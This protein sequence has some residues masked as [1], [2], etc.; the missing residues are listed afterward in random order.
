MI[1]IL[2]PQKRKVFLVIL[3]LFACII[4]KAQNRVTGLVTGNDNK[5]PIIGASVKIKGSTTGTSTNVNGAFSI[6]AKSTDVLEISSIGYETQSVTVGNQTSL[7]VVLLAGTKALNEVV[8]TGYT[9]QRKKDITGAVAVVDVASLKSVPS[10]T[11]ESLLQGQAS[12]VT[13]INSGVPGGNSNVRVRGITSFGNS[14]PLVI[15]DGTPGSLH[16]LNVNDIESM[17]V[18][19][20][21]GSAAIY[22]V[23]G[24]N[25]VVVVTTKKGKQGKAKINFESYVGTQRPLQGNVFNIANPTETGNAIWQEFKNSGIAITPDTYKNSQYGYGSTPVVPYYITPIAGQQGNPNADPSKYALYSNQ[26]TRANQQGTDWFHEIFKPATMQNY[27]LAASGG[28]DKSNFYFS[29]G[30]LD[31][32]GTMIQTHLKRYTARINTNFNIK[33]HIRVGENAYLFYRQN[34]GLPGT[35]QN[36]GNPISYTYRQSPL[37][38]VFDIVG[39]YAGTNS[40]GLGNPQNPYA[41][42]DRTKNNT[43]NDWQMNGNVFAEA[44]FLKHLTARTSFGG[45]IDNYTYNN[46]GY[47]AYENAE[48]NTNPNGFT[49]NYGYNSSWT[50]TNTLRYN[51]VFNKH[52]VT[53]LIGTEAIENYSRAAFGTRNGYYITNPG[54]LTTD[55]NLFTLNFGPPSGQTNGNLNNGMGGASTPYTTSLFSIFGRVDYSFN[56]RY[57]ISG[58]LRRDGSSVFLEDQRFG[59]FPSVTAGWRISQE[60]FMK[61]VSWISDLKLRGGWGKLGSLSNVRPTN[62]FDLFGQVAGNSSYDLGGTSTSSVLG[63]Y[64]SQFGNPITTWEEDKI[65]NIGIDASIF[66]NRFDLSVEWYKK[67]VTGLLFNAPIAATAGGA[68]VPFNNTGDVENHGWDISATYHGA[69]NDNFK[70]DITG[71]FTTYN[72]KVISLKDGVLYQDRVSG[73]SNRFGAFSRLQPGQAVGAFYGY[74]VLG[75]FQNAADVTNSPTQPDA[76]PGRFKYQDI[77]NDGQINNSDRTFFG[78]PNPKYSTGLNLGAS[79]KAFDFSM[80]LY[81]S[82]GNDV[83]NYVKYWTD[84]PQVFDAAMSKDAAVHSFGMPEANG[85]TPILERSANFSNTTVFNSYYMEDGSYLRCKQIQVG[86]TIPSTVMK[87]V[88][89]DRFRVY[90]QAANLFTITKYSGLDPELQ[91]SNVNDNT[92]FGIDF[93]NY[94]GNQKTFN[95][96]VNV[97]F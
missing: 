87:K 13:V 32:E 96:G 18:L 34:P 57:L 39:N 19:K 78:N 14:D 1:H 42:L 22:G 21:A 76:A 93:G 51:Q 60:N 23:R 66:K 7:N 9:A 6:N 90:L 24:S 52:N 95:I 83:I 46:I 75:L 47:T 41:I 8:V 63:S 61:N 86:Y 17:Q 30:Y 69:I 49:E 16:D 92:N 38:P 97:G 29:V 4:V 37:I 15:I 2:L 35:N 59:W 58:T 84:F 68:V 5:Q 64:A 54:S 55:P 81:A 56:D 74:K 45:T 88:G 67:S 25:G 73:G 91:T 44:D 71:T 70:F 43:S 72:N 89:I 53:A 40:K 3:F 11:T 77:N 33:D 94:P 12:G 50:W 62:S 65:S 48:N 28:S 27:S 82:V 85:K 31:Q 79:Y 10:G 26:I 20:D 80:F 36:E